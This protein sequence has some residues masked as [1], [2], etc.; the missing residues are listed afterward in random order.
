M[1]LCCVGRTKR[2]LGVVLLACTLP[3][4]GLCGAA[5]ADVPDRIDA[6]STTTL[7]WSPP[8]LTS[9]T[10]IVI[11]AA[12][13]DLNLPLDRDFVLQMPA[14]ALTGMKG[15]RI[16]GGR[17]VVLIGG[18]ISV[19][20]APA[21][22]TGDDRRGLVLK[23]QTGTV[24]IEGLQIT[25]PALSE[26][27]QIAAPKA[28]VQL[29]NIRVTRV[30]PGDDIAFHSDVL[31]VWGGV[32]ELRV[33]GLTGST[34]FQG[35]FL[36]SDVVGA[37]IGSVDLRRV[38]INGGSGYLFY[39]DPLV[40]S[41]STSELFGLPGPTKQW[42]YS[43]FPS[44]TGGQWGQAVQGTPAG[45]DFVPDGAAGLAYPLITSAPVDVITGVAD[46]GATYAP[47]QRIAFSG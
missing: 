13:R 23:N 31:Q 40:G 43:A 1:T 41:V 38:N 45:G 28:I 21:G 15:L 33:D 27:I 32:R 8:D 44:I 18:T 29:Q 12:K 14:S 7:T 35:I 42:Q 4:V 37:P 2:L 5:A 30:S 22:S 6:V 46:P 39:A 26:G 3:A 36:K 34:T 19:S 17:N 11:T 47:A 10:T 20:D 24:H 9:P 25:G 16:N